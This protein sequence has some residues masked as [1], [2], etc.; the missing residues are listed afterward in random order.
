MKKLVNG[1]MFWCIGW[2]IVS[3]VTMLLMPDM[4]ALVREKGQAA[5]P[6]TTQSEVAKTM[7]NQMKD[8]ESEMYDI[9]AVFNTG[10]DSPLTDEQRTEIDAI[11]GQLQG[12]EQEIGIRKIVSHLDSQEIAAQFIS[13]DRTTILTQ[14][15][16]DMSSGTITEVTDRL[17]EIV[18]TDDIN[19]YLTGNSPVIE[20]FVHS[21]QEGIKK[22]EVIAVIFILVVLILIFRSP[23]VPLVSLAS[24]GVSYLVSFGIIAHLVDGFNYPFSNF[25]QVFLVVILFGIGTDYNI[26]LFTRFKEE[27]SRETDV[28]TAI[29]NTYKSAGRT[30]L[31]SGAA[32][33]IG[34]MALFMAEFKIYRSGSA[35][36]IGVAVLVLV[37]NTLNPFFMGWLG[38][39]LFWP[40]KR[41][42]GH[43]DSRTWGFL[44][45]HSVRRPFAALVIVLLICTP[46][47]MKYSGTLSYNDLLE[48][49][50]S[51]ASKQGIQVIEQH[52]PAGFSSPATIVIQAGHTLDNTESLQALDELAERISKV[53]GVASVHTVT[54]PTGEKIDELYIS[55]QTGELYGGLDEAAVGIDKIYS[56]L[57][58]AEDKFNT[59]DADSLANVQKLIDGTSVIRT[60]AGDLGAALNQ[61]TVG[62]NCG[63]AGARELKT[64]LIMLES[65]LDS[66]SNATAQLVEGYSKL[67]SGLSPA[68]RSFASLSQAIE[69]AITGYEQVESAMTAF[70]QQHPDMAED[71]NIEKTLF[72]ACTGKSQL[73]ELTVQLSQLAP[74]YESA[75]VSF[76]QANSSLQQVEDGLGQFKTGIGQLVEGAAKLERGLKEGSDGSVQIANESKKLESGLAEVNSGQQQLLNGLND[77][78]AKMTTLK[79]GLSESTAGLEKI[80]SG[81]VDAQSYLSGVSESEAAKKFYIP[82]EVLEGED[83]QKSVEMYLS[84]DRKTA[85]ATVI[86]EVN[87]Y[88]KEAMDIIRNMN[89]QVSGTLEGGE[90]AG[91]KVAIGGKSSQN[92]DLQDIAGGDFNRTAIIMLTGI[93]LVLIWITR[94]FWQPAFI[95]ASL[96]LAYGASMGLGELI[97][98]HVLETDHLGWNVPFFSFIMIIALGVDY[99]IF[100]M[101]RYR[102]N[103]GHAGNAIV[104]AARHIGGVVISAAIILGGTFAALIPSGILTLIE[105]AIAV[106]LGLFILSLIMLPVFIPSLM[107][108][109][110]K[111][112]GKETERE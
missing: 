94:S 72:I 10:D 52:F 38:K 6:A 9:I 104:D 47:I 25:T 65:K 98:Y 50:D 49:D 54:R 13:E 75:M 60:G 100:M 82:Q 64:G 44:A 92:A 70:V 78:E 73:G 63:A 8:D 20:D 95:I 80:R 83:F 46:F 39:K 4:D 84:H 56:G 42:E 69:G 16:V 61:V 77:L 31:Y 36:A 1:R 12:R 18:K 2:I 74:Q 93:A 112:S 40:S 43:G 68:A 88:S 110:H 99:S 53:D 103:R 26:L 17:N 86:L 87:P 107:T 29:K 57:S 14:I 96:L 24:V 30:V 34:F 101:M 109:Q 67:E 105:V 5:V 66:L 7:I 58:S 108:I 35:V 51:Y 33:F 90:L 76:K 111:L 79:S 97:G 89:S 106:I 48:V 15:S 37:L 55:E 71:K 27:L 3:V 45:K 62:I 22:T 19:T 85:Q 11:I 28:N 21:T 23:V 81:L 32:V 59:T 91:A 41:F 102:E